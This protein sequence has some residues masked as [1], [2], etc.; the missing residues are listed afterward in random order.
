VFEKA[1]A[2]PDYPA[3]ESGRIKKLADSTGVSAEKK[4]GVW[5]ES[6]LL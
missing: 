4:V 2:R 3:T 1:V 5:R 6:R